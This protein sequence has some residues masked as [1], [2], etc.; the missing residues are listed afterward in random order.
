MKET[1]AQTLEF[2]HAKVGSNP[3]P[4]TKKTSAEKP[5]KSVDFKPFSGFL[6]PCSDVQF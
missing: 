6:M 4:A 5:W 3:A 2:Q 1:T